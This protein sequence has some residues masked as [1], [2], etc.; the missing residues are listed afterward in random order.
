MC[1][2]GG[3]SGRAEPGTPVRTLLVRPNGMGTQRSRSLGCFLGGFCEGGQSPLL[4]VNFHLLR[5][6]QPKPEIITRTP[7]WVWVQ[8]PSPTRGEGV[9]GTP[10]RVVLAGVNFGHLQ[11][12]WCLK[13]AYKGKQI[14]SVPPPYW[15]RHSIWQ[16]SPTQLVG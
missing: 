8:F 5:I 1:S 3:G 13:M 2:T 11:R 15:L 12:I 4:A 16:I 6:N 9:T 10:L 7:F 14:C